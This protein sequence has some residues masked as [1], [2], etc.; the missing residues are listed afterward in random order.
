[1]HFFDL[2]SAD[3]AHILN[4]RFGPGTGLDFG[5][6]RPP[7]SV[8]LLLRRAADLFELCLGFLA[9]CLGGLAD[10]RITFGGRAFGHL[11]GV[12][13]EGRA[14]LGAQRRHDTLER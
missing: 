12:L 3:A 2:R 10:S 7:G 6:S 9:G 14:H 11:G 5:L 8:D 13:L 4:L 1:V